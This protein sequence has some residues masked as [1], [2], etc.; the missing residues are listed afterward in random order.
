MNGQAGGGGWGRGRGGHI[1]KTIKKCHEIKKISTLTSPQNSSENAIN[2]KIFLMS[3]LTILVG[4]FS[5][6]VEL[7]QVGE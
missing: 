4:G 2:V 1:Q 7:F 3:S 5:W 6:E